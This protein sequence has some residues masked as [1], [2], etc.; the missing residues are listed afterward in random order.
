MLKSVITILH[1]IP[2]IKLKISLNDTKI[3]PV[4]RMGKVNML[5]IKPTKK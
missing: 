1:I 4:P 3:I 2:E 5:I